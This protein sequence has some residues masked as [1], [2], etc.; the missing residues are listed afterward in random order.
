MLLH[1]MLT[2]ADKKVITDIVSHYLPGD[3]CKALRSIFK[4]DLTNEHYLYMGEQIGLASMAY[5]IRMQEKGI[6]K[7][8]LLSFN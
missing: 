4:S 3:R 5:Q 6:N 1:T 8:R 7:L 2:T